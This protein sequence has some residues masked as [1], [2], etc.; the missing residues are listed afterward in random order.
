MK[1][2]CPEIVENVHVVQKMSGKMIKFVVRNF[3]C[4]EKL[5]KFWT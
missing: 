4:A 3:S 1:K 2:E 5:D